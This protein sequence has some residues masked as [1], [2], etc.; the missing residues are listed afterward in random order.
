MVCS[1]A[2][3]RGILAD[4]QATIHLPGPPGTVTLGASI[5]G[6]PQCRCREHPSPRLLANVCSISISGLAGSRGSWAEPGTIPFPAS[7]C[8]FSLVSWGRR[9]KG[10]ASQ[11]WPASPSGHT[12]GWHRRVLPGHP[13]SMLRQKPPLKVSGTLEISWDWLRRGVTKP[14]SPLAVRGA[15]AW[16]LVTHLRPGEGHRGSFAQEPPGS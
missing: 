1:L 16:F 8:M 12:L 13:A 3:P 9:S 10:Q 15:L 2:L 4:E 6:C 5:R 14:S 7:A 11:G